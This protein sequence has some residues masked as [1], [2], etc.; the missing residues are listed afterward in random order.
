MRRH[1]PSQCGSFVLFSDRVQLAGTDFY[2]RKLRRYEKSVQQN[3]EQDYEQIGKD[4]PERIKTHPAAL[5]NPQ[6][7]LYAIG[8][9]VNCSPQ[10]CTSLSIPQTRAFVECSR[11]SRAGYFGNGL[12]AETRRNFPTLQ[13]SVHLANP[14]LKAARRA[15]HQR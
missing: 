8:Y 6:E 1:M 10:P 2:Q 9:Q 11:L 3:Q 12:Q 4:A 5:G 13:H 7:D 14:S 15:A